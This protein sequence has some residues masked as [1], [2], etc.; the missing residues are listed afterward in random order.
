MAPAGRDTRPTSDRVREAMF[1]MLESLGAVEGAVVW[2]LFSG[3][4]AMGIEALSRGARHSTFV[5]Q[6]RAAVAATKANLAALGY[7]PGQAS[8][9]PA[10]ALAW[11]AAQPGRLERP[12]QPEGPEGPALALAL[13]PP[14][15][16]PVR[17]GPPSLV[18]A[19]PPY[20]WAQWPA[21]L[22]AVAPHGALVVMETGA[23][24]AL[25]D[26]WVV[27]RRKR[28]G[29][30]VVTLARFTAREDGTEGGRG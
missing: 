20:A 3:S 25:A 15:G 4:G 21:L 1:S 7:G 28:Y 17:P 12:G 29:G 10:D 6:A 13:A 26:G 16:L 24:P 18:F 2:D 19:D 9:V 23:E 8:V 14:P 22:D 30:T 11:S 5:D 27:L